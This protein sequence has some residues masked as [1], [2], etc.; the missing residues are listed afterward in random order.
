MTD[1]EGKFISFWSFTFLVTGNIV[2]VSATLFL[3][4][5]L[6]LDSNRLTIPYD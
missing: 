3:W 6:W 5:C 2:V 1:S 4:K